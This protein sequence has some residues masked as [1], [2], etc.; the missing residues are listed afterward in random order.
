MKLLELRGRDVGTKGSIPVGHSV[1]SLS[2]CSAFPLTN[3]MTTDSSKY[4]SP[5]FATPVEG[6][7][8]SPTG[9]FESWVHLRP[10]SVSREM[11]YC[12]GQARTNCS[13]L[14]PEEGSWYRMYWA[15]QADSNPGSLEMLLTKRGGSRGTALNGFHSSSDLDVWD[16]QHHTTS[17]LQ[18]P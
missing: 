5:I 3:K 18:M 11:G 10:I 14:W 15:A 8:L 13:V 12:G 9:L 4:S 7:L 1:S 16:S 17:R 2:L 6:H